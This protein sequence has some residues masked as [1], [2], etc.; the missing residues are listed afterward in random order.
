[1]T[2]PRSV[3]GLTATITNYS[4]P[5]AGPGSTSKGALLF[6]FEETAFFR[7]GLWLAAACASPISAIVFSLLSRGI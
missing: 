7:F 3:A 6:A 4:V 2:L 5:L 1:M